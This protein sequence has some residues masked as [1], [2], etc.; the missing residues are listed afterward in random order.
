MPKLLDDVRSRCADGWLERPRP[1]RRSEVSD[2][3]M[4]GRYYD[5]RSR[6]K[7]LLRN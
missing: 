2:G 5:R 3:N 7:D 6:N 4:Y 1:D